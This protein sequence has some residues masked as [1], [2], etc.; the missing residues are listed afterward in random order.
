[1]EEV[2]LEFVKESLN[3]NPETGEFFWRFDRPDYH[4]KDWRGRNGFYKNIDPSGKAGSPSKPTKRNPCS[5]IVIGLKGKNY[6]AHRLAWFYHYGEWPDGD[7]DHI[8]LNTL[9]NSI[10]NLR[11]SENKLNHRNR[12]RYR[13]N[14]SGI[15]GVS[16][17]KKLGKWQAEGQQVIEGKRI[18]HYLGVFSYFID[19]CS[20]RKSWELKYDYSENH[21]KNIDKLS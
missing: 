19:A 9:D 17:H 12:S 13:N 15:S 10:A 4:F 8:N 20:A 2:S 1:M 7:I 21:G 6:K 16:F 14:T 18:R 11:I 5:Y 3:Y